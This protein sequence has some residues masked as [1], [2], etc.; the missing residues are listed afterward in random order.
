VRLK[1]NFTPIVNYGQRSSE[2][3]AEVGA[4]ATPSFDVYQISDLTSVVLRRAGAVETV[5][6]A[7]LLPAGT[8][9]GIVAGEGAY[10]VVYTDHFGLMSDPTTIPDAEVPRSLKEL[11]NPKW[12]GKVLLFISPTV[13]WPWVIRLG[14]DEALAALRAV[15]QNGAVA[16]TYPNQLTRFAAKEYP[17]ATTG[18][19]FQQVAQ[20]RGIPSRFTPLDFSANTDHY[21]FVVHGAAH[22]N[23]A[24]L[25]AAALAGP[26]GQR[27][28]SEVVAVGNRY[29]ADTRE[30][31]LEQEALA[32]GFPSF[33]WADS[34]DAVAFV[35]SPEGEEVQRELERIFQ[36]G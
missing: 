15:V 12:R 11:G 20:A 34:P 14:R 4:G 27:L 29:Y 33:T 28:E 3:L 31:T 21:A 8:P 1:I 19:T 26:E 32:A 7:P 10:V 16:E 6:W 22:P 30:H 24:R 9:P 13:Y 18:V 17:L 5:N 25:L 23:A 35:L 2:L 36:G